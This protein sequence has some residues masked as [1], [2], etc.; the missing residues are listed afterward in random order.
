MLGGSNLPP[1]VN[2]VL[3]TTFGRPLRKFESRLQNKLAFQA[4]ALSTLIS[5]LAF[6]LAT[7]SAETEWSPLLSP[8]AHAPGFTQL[9]PAQTG[10]LF[11]NTLDDWSAAANRVLQNGS[12]VACGDYDRD[13]RPDIF[14][15]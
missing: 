3:N 11:T 8:T 9:S 2:S 6:L 13:G 12:G 7:V 5:L 10:I 1:S 14:L 15:C 4:R